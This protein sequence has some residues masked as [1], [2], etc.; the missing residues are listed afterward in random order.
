MKTFEQKTAK[1]GRL[2]KLSAKLKTH[3]ASD[4]DEDAIASANLK[5]P[6]ESGRQRQS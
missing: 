2:I 6:L 5:Q 4:A 1:V 3:C